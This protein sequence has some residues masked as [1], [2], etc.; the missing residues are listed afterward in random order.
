MDILTKDAAKSKNSE[1]TSFLCSKKPNSNNKVK[2]GGV[3]LV[4]FWYAGGFVFNFS[5]G[6]GE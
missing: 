2:G 4:Y 1:S 5:S 3:W 6:V